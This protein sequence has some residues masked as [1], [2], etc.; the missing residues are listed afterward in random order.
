[1]PDSPTIS[2]ILI[3]KNER[4]NIADC[5]RTLGFCDEIVIVDSGSSDGTADIARD[6]GA[7]VH[8]A[9][10]WPGFGVQKQRALDRATGDWVLSVDADERVPDKLRE[11]IEAA[12][13][14][15]RYAGYQVNR[16]SWFLGQPLHHGGWHPDYILRLARRDTAQFQPAMVHET[17]DVD[18]EVGR[19]AEPLVHHSYR[20][21]DDVLAK[22]RRYALASAEMRRRDGIRGGL[23]A[24]IIRSLFSFLKAYFLQAGLLDGRRGFVA[25]L[26]RSQETFWRYL[27]VGWE[28]SP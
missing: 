27:A 7:K 17:L 28:K 4:E 24:A 16:L 3:V 10:D 8:V 12:V 13:A 1:M 23:L 21:I 25:A 20:T 5:V 2:A 9:A 14:D 15:D 22:L 6:L 19:L 11:E 26:F 18:G